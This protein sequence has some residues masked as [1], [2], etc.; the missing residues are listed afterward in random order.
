MYSAEGHSRALV[1][2]SKNISDIRG[3]SKG[4]TLH[5][6]FLR[7]LA[8]PTSD[9]WWCKRLQNVDICCNVNGQRCVRFAI[10]V[11]CR[12]LSFGGESVVFITGVTIGVVKGP[13][14]GGPNHVAGSCCLCHQFL[15]F[16][17]LSILFLSC[18]LFKFSRICDNP[19]LSCKP[20]PCISQDNRWQWAIKIIPEGTSAKT[21]AIMV[22]SSSDSV[23]TDTWRAC[24]NRGS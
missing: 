19:L 8:T 20:P 22:L 14:T 6:L 3:E 18:F 12:L 5:I 11:R 13:F 10:G 15:L 4:S 21:S 7:F 16:L 2:A 17:I 24:T 9:C 23:I 1:M